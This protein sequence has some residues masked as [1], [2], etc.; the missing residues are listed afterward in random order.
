MQRAHARKSEISEDLE[1]TLERIASGEEKLVKYPSFDEYKKHVKQ[2]LEEEQVLRRVEARD[3]TID[4]KLKKF[5]SDKT[6]IDGYYRVL[7][8]LEKA[9]DP[10]KIGKRKHGRYKNC[11][12]EH[13]TKNI[14]L[15]FMYYREQD[16]VQLIDLDDHK[17]LFGRDNRS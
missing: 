9:S 17:T 14:S 11:N 1:N 10:Y 5:R 8:D 13:I 4:R 7:E 6:I 3:D 12:A 16:L 15:V 2:V